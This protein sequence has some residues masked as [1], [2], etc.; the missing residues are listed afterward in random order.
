[1]SYNINF[2]DPT[3]P[4][5]RNPLTVDDQ[6]LNTQTDLVF[7]GKNFP[8]YAQFIAENFLA[9]LENFAAVTPPNNPVKGQLWYDTGTS[10][11]PDKPQLRLWDGT[12]WTEAGNVKKALVKPSVNE[13]IAGDL[14]VDTTNQQ[15][16]LFSGSTWVLVG[17]QFNEASTTG[18]K[19]E[20]I[21]DRATNLPKPVISAFIEDQRV[22]IFSKYQFVPKTTLDGFAEIKQG[23]TMSTQDFDLDGNMLNKFWGTSEK[24]DAMV[25]GNATVP[26]SN[27]L[28]GDVVSTTNF[29]LNIRS[30][31]GLAVGQSLETSLTSIGSGT[32]LQQTIPGRSIVLRTTDSPNSTNDVVIIKGDKTVG[33]NTVPTEALDVNGKIL[34]N[35]TIRTTST[36]DSTSSI[37]GSLITA[38][39]LG[40]AKALNVGSTANINGV[41]TAGPAAISTTMG[42]APTVHNLL[43]IGSPIKR[44]NN[45]YANG[46]IG[47]TFAGNLIGDV[48]G[49]VSGRAS[50]LTN[51][52]SFSIIGDITAP[53]V[54]F[55]GT[56]NVTFDTTI[57][58]EIISAKDEI[59]E[60]DENDFFLVYKT[61]ASSPRL[62]KVAKSTLFNN[63]GSVPVGSIFPFAGETVPSGYLLCD[64][65]EQRRSLYSALFG[66]IGFKYRA[67][68]LLT[69]YLTFALPDLRGRFPL[70]LEA[71]DNGSSISVETKATNVLRPAVF[72]NAVVGY[73]V[74][75]SSN[76]IKGPFQINKA[77]TGTGFDVSAG[78]AVITEIR[79][80]QDQNGN[81]SPG[82]TTLVLTL[83]PQPALTAATVSEIVSYGTI[84][85]GGGTPSPTRVAAANAIGAVGGT[86]QRTLTTNQLPQHSHTLQSST[87]TQYYAYREG[88][89][90][91]TDGSISGTLHTSF[92]SARLSP[93][94]G[95]INAT[96]AVGQPIDVTNPFLTINYI[97]YAGA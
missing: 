32:V 10:S 87:G 46:F 50:Q 89:G 43:D 48:T 33:I 56:G 28:R 49:N 53:S 45:V 23:I 11:D 6:A 16:Y 7:V 44:W 97:I 90:S 77:I 73:L 38:G 31:S 76:I 72:T 5:A 95:N 12:N 55:N 1:M 39:G 63:L 18:L 29:Q 93:N 61:T 60:L 94:T 59:A 70:G 86:S 17:P 71:M 74:I 8:N 96:G 69:G 14:W 82:T 40:V 54:L 75:P 79:Y 85:A 21:I 68:A 58:D 15:L 84:D 78:A 57:G 2:T 64:G 34:S 52:R 19:V 81:P 36:T 35:D 26:S 83:P 88:T 66:V 67:E 22:S 41:L 13:S 80:D 42:L 91:G 24:A 3:N 20:E 47:G 62:R 9:L 4:D 37:T 30:I 65:S 27:F 25:V 92:D 51:S